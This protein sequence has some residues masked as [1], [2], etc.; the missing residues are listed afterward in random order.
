M[1][2]QQRTYKHGAQLDTT[3]HR[4]P[5]ERLPTKHDTSN[6]P[7]TRLKA[8]PGW[9]EQSAKRDSTAITIP[10]SPTDGKT[11][12]LIKSEDDPSLIPEELILAPSNLSILAEP[13]RI[14]TTYPSPPPIEYATSDD[15]GDSHKV[16]AAKTSTTSSYSTATLEIPPKRPKTPAQSHP[17][18]QMIL[19]SY[20]KFLFWLL[21][22]QKCFKQRKC[23]TLAPTRKETKH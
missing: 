4:T 16:E 19:R 11:T 6:E 23:G 15:E 5:Y 17:W 8:Q 18:T 22:S 20:I 2:W 3:K 21:T 12:I 1:R 7:R 9:T 14:F 13:T 10:K